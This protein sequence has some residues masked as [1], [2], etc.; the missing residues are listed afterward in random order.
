MK[1]QHRTAFGLRLWLLVS[2]ALALGGFANGQNVVWGPFRL[3][4]GATA[5]FEFTDNANSSDHNPKPDVKLTVGPTLSGGIQVPFAGGQEFTLIMAVSYTHSF[6]GISAD[7]FSASLGATL[8]LP[9]AVGGWTVVVGDSFSFSNDPLE[10]TFA[11]NRSKVTQYQ[12]TVS[13]S[14]TRQ[15]GRYSLTLAGQR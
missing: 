9:I 14:G 13:A 5:G 8:T 2:G 11:V 4:A 6:T 12:N 3:T 1:Q 10:S 15:L 7:G